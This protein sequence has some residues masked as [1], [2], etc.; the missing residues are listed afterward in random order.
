MIPG[1][2]KIKL[3]FFYQ[4]L[5]SKLMNSIIYIIIFRVEGLQAG[6][7]EPTFKRIMEKEAYNDPVKTRYVFLHSDWLT[8]FI[9]SRQQQILAQKK[10]LGKAFL[11]SDGE[12]RKKLPSFWA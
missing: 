12:K 9:F 7:F 11:P 5:L 8:F 1:G 3:V 10:N 2:S 6:Y 4:P